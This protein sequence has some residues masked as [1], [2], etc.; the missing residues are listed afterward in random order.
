[1]AKKSIGFIK[2]QW[3]CPNC[4]TKN[5][6]PNKFCTGCGAAQP[7]DV[8]FEQPERQ[9]LIKDE[10]EIRRAKAGPDIHCAFCGTR[11][12]GDAKFCGQCG[13][14]LQEGKIREEGQVMGAYQTGPQKQVACPSCGAMNVDTA[15]QCE[16]CGAPLERKAAA[17]PAVKPE[18]APMKPGIGCVI[19]AVLGILGL[20]LIVALL[21]AGGKTEGVEATLQS[22]GWERLVFIQGLKP[23]NRQAFIDQ[24]PANASIGSCEDR[25]HHSEDEPVENSVEACGTPYTVDTGSGYAEVIQDCVYEVYL[26]YCNYTVEEW[27]VVD[28][29][30]LQGSDR[31]PQWPNPQLEANERLGDTRESYSAIF[32]TDEGQMTYTFSDE[33]LYEQ[34]IPGSQW[35]LLVNN[36]G[37][38]VSIEA[39]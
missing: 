26:E 20:I 25:Y 11:N 35:V 2:L 38:I 15:Y 17:P 19:A 18:K 5:P 27:Q 23:V 10:E 7:A 29:V 32:S 9:D 16:N 28:Q 1:M 24:I 31:S 34:L 12:F 3:L 21:S 37:Q 4:G 36:S 14:D 8:K 33:D 13:G 30:I 6:G 39:E 22:A